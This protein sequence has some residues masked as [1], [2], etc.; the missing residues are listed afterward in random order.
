[1]AAADRWLLSDWVG[2]VAGWR[3]D[4]PMAASPPITTT[5]ESNSG[6]ARLLRFG[7]ASGSLSGGLVLDLERRG[8]MVAFLLTTGRDVVGI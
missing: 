4:E 1:V 3:P 7:F 5:R 2:G 6:P 8:I